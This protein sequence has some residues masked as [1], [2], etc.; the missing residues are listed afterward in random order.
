MNT[1]T[2]QTEDIGNV[3]EMVEKSYEEELLPVKLTEADRLERADAYAKAQELI[4]KLDD[5][6]KA[7]TERMKA[8]RSKHETMVSLYARELRKGTTDRQVSVETVKNFREGTVIKRRTD[9]GEE[10]NRREMTEK[11]R[12]LGLKGL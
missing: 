4:E 2:Q 3:D 5:E 10:L 12:Q 11:E 1:P 9:T 6:K 7:V 8:E